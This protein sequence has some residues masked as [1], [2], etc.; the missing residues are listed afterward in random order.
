MPTLATMVQQLIRKRGLGFT[1]LN[2]DIGALAAGSFTS[3]LWA[4]NGNAA[5]NDFR[6][7]GYV[8]WR[9]ASASPPA[10]T[11]RYA[12]DLAKD[13]GVVSVDVNWADTTLGSEDIYMLRKIHP[14]YIIDA[15]MLALGKAYFPNVEPLSLKPVGT[16]LADAGF[17]SV[18]TT[19]YI[20][21]TSTFTKH[22]TANSSHVLRGIAS[23]KV[24]N[25]G[26]NGGIY[27]QYEI[28]E[29]DQVVVHVASKL[30]TGTA[31]VLSLFDATGGVT[32]GAN[33]THSEKRWQYMRRV[34]TNPG[35]LLDVRLLGSG[36]SD[37]TY[38]N[39]IH[40]MPQSTRRMFLDTKWDTAW[41]MPAIVYA[42]LRQSTGDGV[43]D[44]F[45]SDLTEVPAECYSFD[46]ERPGANPY[47]VQFHLGIEKYL[48]KPLFIQ[49]RRAY[50]DITTSLSISDLTTS[51]SIDL[52][53]WE[54]QTA[55]ELL[56]MDD[57]AKVVPDAGQRLAKA[58]EDR[59][60]AARQGMIDGPAKRTTNT[61]SF[62][63]V[64]N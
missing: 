37:E 33:V 18:A 41:K 10:D 31:A 62:G 6:S 43:Y 38:W 51:V 11:V 39:A 20:T 2:A 47:A 63:R 15:A 5:T 12:A 52:D 34:E 4:R 50:S 53:L 57:V 8:V 17:Q 1:I 64:G 59:N 44:A 28:S 7:Q 36:A 23:G 40:V 60:E 27:Q 21:I 16:T 25:S 29:D 48:D 30:D 13:T 35:K 14:R 46:M 24:V 58:L 54:A 45:A 3:V 56:S 42:D 19:S 61:A 49:G 26:A 9:P 32:I 22:T 55:V